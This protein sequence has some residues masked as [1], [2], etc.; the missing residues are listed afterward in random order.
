KVGSALPSSE[1]SATHQRVEAGITAVADQLGELS[2]LLDRSRADVDEILKSIEVL[3]AK[4]NQS[5]E[6]ASS[7]NKVV[8]ER[9]TSLRELSEQI[10]NAERDWA[11]LTRKIEGIGDAELE[12]TRKRTEWLAGIAN[13]RALLEAQAKI[14]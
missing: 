3:L 9:L 12:L 11:S 14:L 4:H 6:A 8:Q 5:Y 1:L 2:K 13:K 10:S 7:E